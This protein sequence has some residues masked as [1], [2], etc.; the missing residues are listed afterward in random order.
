[1]KTRCL[2]LAACWISA[3]L[4]LPAQTLP[5]RKLATLD[6]MIRKL[7]ENKHAVGF[8]RV[9]HSA[10][11][12]HRPFILKLNT[13]DSVKEL[14]VKPDGHIILPPLA[15]EEWD[16]SSVTHN[17]EKGALALTFG[18]QLMDVVPTLTID[19][20][21]AAHIHAMKGFFAAD[22]EEFNQLTAVSPTMKGQVIAITGMVLSSDGSG[23]GEASLVAGDRKA[24]SIDL[25]KKGRVVWNFEQYDPAKHRLVV[26][27]ETGLQ[28][29]TIPVISS[30]DR[31]PGNAVEFFQFK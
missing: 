11:D 9:E 5:Y 1:M 28:V 15:E 8:L 27:Q 22:L 7:S 6:R 23:E 14:E 29:Q 25:S 21:L 26:D 12:D 13:P 24:A 30:R 19:S 3:A 31:L 16:K 18:V 20:D 10:P 2:L 4:P 17:L